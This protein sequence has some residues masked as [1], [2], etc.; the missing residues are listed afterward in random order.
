MRRAE[1]EQIENGLDNF[2]GIDTVKTVARDAAES[3]SRAAREANDTSMYVSQMTKTLLTWVKH[4][5]N[6]EDVRVAQTKQQ[7]R[8]AKLG[9]MRSFWKSKTKRI[10]FSDDAKIEPTT[11]HIDRDE[12]APNHHSGDVGFER[13]LEYARSGDALAMLRVLESDEQVPRCV[14]GNL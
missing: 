14:T 3:A 6:I 5:R 4:G 7:A 8:E 10:T 12:S 9:Y 2:W 1:N 11:R 13:V